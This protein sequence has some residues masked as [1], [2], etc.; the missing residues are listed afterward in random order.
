L[1]FLGHFVTRRLAQVFFTHGHKFRN[2]GLFCAKKRRMQCFYKCVKIISRLFE[3]L[4][5][6]V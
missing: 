5:K 2:F 6:I 4:F 1:Q 3:I